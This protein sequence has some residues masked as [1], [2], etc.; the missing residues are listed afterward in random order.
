V[1]QLWSVAG[2]DDRTDVN[3]MF[4]Q[5]FLS[6]ALGM[7]RTVVINTESTYDWERH[8]W[9]VPV[10][11]GYSRVTKLGKQLVSWQGGVRGYLDA[12]EGGPDWGVR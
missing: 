9:K 11:L 7:G 6:K 1:N 12:P 5:P 2:D 4:L 3:A 8:Q 10:N